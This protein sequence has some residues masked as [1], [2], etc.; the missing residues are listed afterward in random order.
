M[1]TKNIIKWLALPAV[2]GLLSL[3]TA[4]A[5]T[6]LGDN[7]YA[8]KYTPTSSTYLL[9]TVIP[10]IEGNGGQVNRDVLMTNNLLAVTLGLQSGS[11]PGTTNDPLYSRT[12]LAGSGTATAT[13][14]AFASGLGGGSGPTIT[15]DLNHFGTFTYL[16]V[17]YDGA[18]SGVAIWDIA[19]LT[20]NITFAAYAFPELNG[21]GPTETGNL[22]NGGGIQQYR[23]TSWT[24]LNPTSAPDG[25]A[26]VMLLGAA[27]GALGMVRRYL[28]S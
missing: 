17:A 11:N 3:A 6:T 24:L 8:A 7:I 21:L 18:N 4:Q 2:L 20:G 19:G 16:V 13:N 1:K 5:D 12:T 23:I 28:F 10:G 25:G 14:A 15:I 22:L 27:L 26:T 9:G